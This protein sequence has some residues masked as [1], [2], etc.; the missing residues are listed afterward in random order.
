MSR[1]NFNA[2]YPVKLLIH[3]YRINAES[4]RQARLGIWTLQ[5]WW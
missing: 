2:I 1:L 5:G 3:M 4:A